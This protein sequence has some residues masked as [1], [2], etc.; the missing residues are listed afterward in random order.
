MTAQASGY[1]LLLTGWRNAKAEIEA[2]MR[3]MRGRVDG[4]IAMSPHIDAETLFDNLPA[5]EPVVLLSCRMHDEDHGGIT[6]DNVGGAREMVTHLV[7]L[8]HRRIAIIKGAQGNYDASERLRGYRKALKEAGIAPDAS[9]EAEGD[10]VETSG[11]RAAL[12]LARLRAPPTAIFAAND[13]MAIGALSALREQGLRVPR[14]MAVV[15]FDDIPL[16]RYMDPPL[17]SVHVPIL[18]MAER[19]ARRLIAA[20]AGD[21]FDQGRLERLPT[22][23]VLRASS[24]Q[25]LKKSHRRT[26]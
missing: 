5:T 26:K 19:A 6:I 24:G 3:A 4:M 1:H 18:E 2:A 11:H 23:L 14:D 12:E 9:L 10:F 8:G 13:A 20:L 15:G 17:S 16:A 22:R 21:P 25:P 7:S